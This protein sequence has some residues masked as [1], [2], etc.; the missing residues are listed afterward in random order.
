M[1]KKAFELSGNSSFLRPNPVFFDFSEP[2]RKEPGMQMPCVY[3][4]R[5]YDFVPLI[6]FGPS[7]FRSSSRLRVK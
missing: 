1:A 5:K 6:E 2:G 4:K 7:G 3:G